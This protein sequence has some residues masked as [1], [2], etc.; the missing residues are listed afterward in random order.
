MLTATVFKLDHMYVYNDIVTVAIFVVDF[1]CD[2]R[3]EVLAQQN[4]AG[5]T[6]W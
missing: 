3:R 2:T 4:A 5:S 6:K 1:G